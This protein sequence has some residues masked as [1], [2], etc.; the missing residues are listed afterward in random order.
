MVTSCFSYS[1]VTMT[2]VV[3]TATKSRETVSK[4]VRT[5]EKRKKTS[6][7][8]KY[9]VRNPKISERDFLVLRRF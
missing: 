1:D 9:S 8:E 7:S 4:V 6:S 5:N 2:A 3:K